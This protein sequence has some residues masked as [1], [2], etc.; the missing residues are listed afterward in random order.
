MRKPPTILV[1]EDE[2]AIA[3]LIRINLRHSGYEV[4]WA[5]DG[6]AAQAALESQLPDLILL[7]WMLPGESGIALAKRWRADARTKA[8]PIILL[9]ARNEENDRVA[10]LDAGADD[11]IGKPFSTK[12]LL[13]RIR[14]VLRRRV[15]A[16]ENTIWTL[17]AL[18]LDAGT[19]R[20]EHD[21]QPVKLGPTEFKLL[22]HFMEN[23]ERVRS[24]A[25][26]LQQVWGD[27]ADIEE[28]TVDVHIK[29]LREA[30]GTAGHMIQTV[31]GTGYR[32]TA[33]P[34]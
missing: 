34:D 20:V 25:Q 13:A 6:S 16:P 8:T 14:A 26:L 9:T 24:R 19:H 3:E 4:V 23:A 7:D 15:P 22:H 10:G 12:E 30:L 27:H 32:I 21:G 31:R 29:R 1:V 2:A 17:G 11:Y 28:R 18:T 5:A 33:Q